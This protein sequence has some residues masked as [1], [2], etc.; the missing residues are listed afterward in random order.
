[1]TSDQL[2]VEYTA[3]AIAEN[4]YSQCVS[5]GCRFVL[6]SESTDHRRMKW[7]TKDDG[8]VIGVNGSKVP[9]KQYKDG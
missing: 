1:M 6:L 2:M 7:Y 3:N 4:L 9:R 5:E 8:Y